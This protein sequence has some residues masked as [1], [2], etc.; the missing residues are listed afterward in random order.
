MYNTFRALRLKPT[1]FY[2]FLKYG[3]VLDEIKNKQHETQFLL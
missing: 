2:R 3:D 1:R